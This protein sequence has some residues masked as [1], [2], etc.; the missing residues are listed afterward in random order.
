MQYEIPTA[1]DEISAQVQQALGLEAPPAFEPV[2]P[3]FT[4]DFAL[5]VFAFAH[6]AG[7]SAHDIARELAETLHHPA[8]HKAEAAGGFVNLWLNAEFIARSMRQVLA[9]PTFGAH[10]PSTAQKILIEVNNLNP[11]KDLHIGHAYN[12]IVSDTLSNLLELGGHVVH[13]V[14][15]HGDVGLHVGKSM[16]AILRFTGGDF[17]KLESIEPRERAVF[18]SRMYVEGAGEYDED[19]LVREQIAG[20]AQQSFVLDDP[21]YKAIYDECKQWSFDYIHQTLPRLGCQ[22]SEREYLE[23]EADALGRQTVE[24]HIGDVFERSEGAVVFRGE[25]HGLHTRV[26]ISSNDTTLYEARDLGLMQLKNNEYHPD[27]SYIVTAEEQRAYFEVVFKAAALVLPELAGKTINI[28][29]G[30]VK[31]STGKMSS[32]SG[33]VVNI[34]WLFTTFAEALKARG[35]GEASLHDGIVGALRY[36]MLRIRIGGDIVIDINESVSL[37]GNSG[38]YLQYA[39]ARG[40]SILAKAGEASELTADFTNDERA[41]AMKVLAYPRVT[42]A[43]VAELAPH[44]ITTYLYELTQQF[45]RFYENNRIVGD[46]RQTQRAAITSAYCR[47]LKNGLSTLGIPAP[48]RL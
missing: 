44:H 48:D 27:T 28:P 42:R 46:P 16:W 19:P 22:P 11:F 31:L 37:E 10:K 6:E 9:Q 14:S 21:A 1:L 7:R 43:A 26:F 18:L 38:P 33:Q 32:R 20:L 8:L 41:L 35:A 2:N 45:N 30:T 17:K 25:P 5:P 23:H 40:R 15:Y 34:E 12:S 4:A 3:K 29:H 36:A 13:R 24:A 47:V 39:H